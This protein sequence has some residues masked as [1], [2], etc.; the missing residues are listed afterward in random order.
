MPDTHNVYEIE[1]DVP[2]SRRDAFEEWLSEDIV[3]WVSHETIA[4]FQVFQNDTG[5]SPEVKFVFGFETLEE[6]ATF[7]GSAAHEDA[8]ESLSGLAENREAI[9]WQ[10][11]S[12]KLDET[13]D[14]PVGDGGT[15][16]TNERHSAD[17]VLSQ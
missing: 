12:V 3:E 14:R 4:Y 16:R 5:M 10:R 11:A 8:I 17:A 15:I 6:W 9:L 1:F 2:A 13:L 7:V